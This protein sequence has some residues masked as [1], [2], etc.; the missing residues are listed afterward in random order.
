[1]EKNRHIL[2]DALQHLQNFSPKQGAWEEIQKDLSEAPLKEAVSKLKSISPPEQIWDAISDEKAKQEK[3]SQLKTYTPDAEIWDQID[4]SLNADAKKK[5]FI[6]TFRITSWAAAAAMLILMGCFLIIQSKQTGN[7]SY[8]FEIVETENVNLWQNDD[9]E[10]MEAL[11]EICT[12]NPLVCETP[13][14]KQKQKELRFLNEQKD[15]ILQN[16]N[17][18]EKNKQ[19]EITLTKIEL[20]KNDLVKAMISEIL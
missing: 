11:K 13:G 15:R 5:S 3:L 8:S 4:K 1:M 19:L 18:Y 10:I 12:S 14:F 9:S 16:L 6:R 2:K 17:S 20:E 7:I